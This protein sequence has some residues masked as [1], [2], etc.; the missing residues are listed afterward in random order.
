[1]A[2]KLQTKV[3]FF[4]VFHVM[5]FILLYS[6]PIHL[7]IWN[8]ICLFKQLTGKNCWNCGMTRAF[9]SIL[10]FDF[11]MAYQ[12]NHKVFLVFPLTVGIYLYSWYKFIFLRKGR[13]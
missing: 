6:I 7:D 13:E 9:L 8:K 2:M 10:H 11:S 1:M 5:L 3:L 12:Y 4:I